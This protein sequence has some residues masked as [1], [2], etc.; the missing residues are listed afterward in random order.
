[1][2]V[3]P[4][5]VAVPKT[6]LVGDADRYVKAGSLVILRC[7]VHGSL[8]P[9]SYIIWY[10]GSQQLLPDNRRGFKMQMGKTTA[11]A[12]TVDIG[13]GRQERIA[14]GSVDVVSACPP[15]KRTGA[16]RCDTVFNANL[17]G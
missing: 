4:L 14:G 11:S 10:H 3:C 6:E 5:S 15:R 16:V 8:E 13:D 1:M 7:L 12:A 2:C 17:C 9:P